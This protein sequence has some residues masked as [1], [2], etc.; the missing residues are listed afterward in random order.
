MISD[1]LIHKN[2]NYWDNFYKK[3]LINKESSFCKK[4]RNELQGDFI[5]VD[6]GCG[7]GRDSF[8]FA[9]EGYDV[10]GIDGSEEAISTNKKRVEQIRPIGEVYFSKVD[11]SDQKSL[12]EI[13]TVV[14]S[15]AD[16]ENKRII[17]Y[18]RFLLHAIDVETEKILL[19]TLVE[20]TPIGTCF[21]AEFRTAEDAVRS[22]VYDD[23]YRRFV[24][25]DTFLVELINRGF[26]VN[27]FYKGTGFSIYKD[28]DPF[29][30]RVIAE[31]R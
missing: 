5:V 11:L 10:F 25:T 18:L 1:K 30:A 26:S 7:L 19:D 23:H 24:E 15:K 21:V 29:L 16:L 14:T 13:L 20:N 6:I 4:I 22:K 9:E 2:S 31:K 28:E 12:Q 27:K 3:Q 8:S 17:L